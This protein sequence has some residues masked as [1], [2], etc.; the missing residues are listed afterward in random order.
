MKKHANISIFVTH[1]GCPQQCSFCN[2]RYIARTLTQPTKE[3]IDEAVKITLSSKNYDPESTEIAF[4]GGSF[5]AIDRDY[6]ISLLEAA[7]EYVKNG[8]V[9]GIRISTRPDAI[10][11]EILKIL[12]KYGVTAIELGAQSLSDEVLALNRRGHT[13][14]DVE[15]ASLLIKQEGFS[16]GL[17]MM[18]G[19]LGDSD[20]KSIE[21]AR[22]IIEFAPDTVRIY[23]TIV[24]EDTYLGELYK[25]GEYSPQD[26][27]SAVR[28]TLELL[29]MF[30]ASG[31]SVIRTGLH[32]I[33]EEKYLAG[34]WHPAFRELCD[35]Q[36]YLEIAKNTLNEQ[37]EYI[38][39]VKKGS[40]S[41][42][43]G[44]KRK[45][46]QALKQLGFNCKIAEDEALKDFEIKVERV[47]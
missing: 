2:Q 23:P 42:M 11:P 45:N 12:K 35:A 43:S 33:D 46:V 3:T 8:T 15:T 14:K 41:K 39:Y 16:L 31:I 19:L 4:F 10:N 47:G 17:Q 32:T 7:W 26:L 40:L 6:M 30:S 44:Q 18:T 22:K 29:Q 36:V 37:G 27:E 20:E 25:A 21:T 13:A 24:L 9:K 1:L 28:L 34:P 38:I 5:T